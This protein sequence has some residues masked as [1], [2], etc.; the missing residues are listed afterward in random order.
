MVL[1]HLYSG[2]FCGRLPVLT[3]LALLSLAQSHFGVFTGDP[4]L[5]RVP[6]D[7]Q[8]NAW[9]TQHCIFAI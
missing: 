3:M 6:G 5:P 7:V 1:H 8:S 9:E 4:L 2:M